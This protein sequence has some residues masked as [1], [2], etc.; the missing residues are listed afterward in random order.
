MVGLGAAEAGVMSKA[1]VRILCMMVL[2]LTVAV[3]FQS[4]RTRQMMIS[5]FDASTAIADV[6]RSHG[7]ELRENSV[8]PPRLL[9]VVVYFQRPGCNRP[10]LVLP[11]L[12]NAEVEPLLARLTEP[13]FE[14]HFYYMDSSWREQH[15]VAMFLE[16]LKHA[17]LD[18]AGASRYVPVKKAIVLADPP[19]CHPADVIDWRVLW[20]KERPRN[21]VNAGG[22]PA[23]RAVRS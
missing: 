3:R 2:L 13:G 16:W 19:D 14:R 22:T 23:S 5:E 11:Y 1:A 6:L 8:K 21:P 10:S 18:L 7:L 17:A 9:S 20:E 12:I 4:D 15:R